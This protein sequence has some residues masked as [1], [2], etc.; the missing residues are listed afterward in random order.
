MYIIFIND[1]PF[2]SISIS[3]MIIPITN[4]NIIVRDIFFY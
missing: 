4:W 2:H 3:I 1:F